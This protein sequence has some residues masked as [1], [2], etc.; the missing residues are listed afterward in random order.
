MLT[1]G[2]VKTLLRDR[3]ISDR[4][5]VTLLAAIVESKERDRVVVN[6][7]VLA[8]SR[9]LDEMTVLHDLEEAADAGW[10]VPSGKH[11]K[12]VR[13]IGLPA[14]P[15]EAIVKPH[16]TVKVRQ[17]GSAFNEVPVRQWQ[18]VHFAQYFISIYKGNKEIPPTIA[19]TRGIVKNGITRLA[20]MHPY[21]RHDKIVYRDYITWAVHHHQYRAHYILQ[22]KD[23]MEEFLNQYR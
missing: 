21:I 13:C 12:T 22:D 1:R 17:S 16:T 4:V 2:W 18:A 8:Q 11:E 20:T 10:Y 15:G 23:L 6:V 19:L 14:T 7:E 5:K 9:G 3:S